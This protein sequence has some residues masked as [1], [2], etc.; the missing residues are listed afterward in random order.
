MAQIRSVVYTDLPGQARQIREK[1]SQLNTS[2]HV[3]YQSINE[4]RVNWY[5]KRYN[6]LVLAFNG[7]IQDFNAV[8]DL[9][10][11]EVPSTL[12]TVANNYSMVD[13]GAAMT[14]VDNTP[15]QKLLDIMLSTEPGMKFQTTEVEAVKQKCN[16]CFADV[17]AFLDELQTMVIKLS[18]ESDASDKFRERFLSLRTR[19]T[20]SIEQIKGQFNN[21]VQQTLADM[22]STE[23]ANT[24][25]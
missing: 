4:M 24:V 1:A 16:N 9:M 13:R 22:Q 11:R 3:I 23:T 15:A 14:Q 12:E 19:I 10:F 17:L 5:G 20:T 2:L 21:S 6:D 25:G 18:W 7:M 8:V